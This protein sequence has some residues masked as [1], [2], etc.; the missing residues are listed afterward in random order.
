MELDIIIHRWACR[1]GSEKAVGQ[2]PW[3]PL[4]LL[5]GS[6]RT[7]VC[8]PWV[9][10]KSSFSSKRENKNMNYGQMRCSHLCWDSTEPPGGRAATLLF[11]LQ[12]SGVTAVITAWTVLEPGLGD[13]RLYI[14]IPWRNALSIYETAVHKGRKNF[15]PFKLQETVDAFCLEKQSNSTGKISAITLWL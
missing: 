8:P 4:S 9:Q 3:H 1:A 10:G 14:T 2:V 12:Q 5:R 7:L 15:Y 6:Q 13:E 11:A